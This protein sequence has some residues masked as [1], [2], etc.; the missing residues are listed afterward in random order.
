MALFKIHDWLARTRSVMLVR[1]VQATSRIVDDVFPRTVRARMVKQA[2]ARME[3]PE[4]APEV[5]L[6]QG[7][8]KALTAIQ[9]FVGLEAAQTRAVQRKSSVLADAQPGGAIADTFPSVTV[10]FSDVVGF[11][12]WSSGVPPDVVFRVLGSMFAEFDALAHRLGIFKVETSALTH[13]HADSSH[14]SALTRIRLR[15]RRLLYGGLWA[16]RADGGARGAH[17]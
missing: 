6:S 3:Q 17:G 12:Q 15:S 10:L 13:T 14:A 2:L 8:V 1:M 11:T 5:P 7:A 4:P 9:K 16:A